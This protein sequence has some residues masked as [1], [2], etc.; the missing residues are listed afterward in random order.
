M[1]LVLAMVQLK[2]LLELMVLVLVQLKG[3]LHLMVLVQLGE[4]L[5]RSWCWCN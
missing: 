4:L 2:G 5:Q 1:V 3:L